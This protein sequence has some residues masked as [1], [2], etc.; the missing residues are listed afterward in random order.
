MKIPFSIWHGVPA[1]EV[2]SASLSLSSLSQQLRVQLWARSGRLE[3]AH[4]L[5]VVAVVGAA[6]VAVDGAEKSHYY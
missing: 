2:A 5:A 4:R 3:D 6:A 1:I